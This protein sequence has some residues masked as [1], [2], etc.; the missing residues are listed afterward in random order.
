MLYNVAGY[1]AVHL[2]LDNG[3]AIMIGSDEAQR[4][5]AVI[6]RARQ[7]RRAHASARR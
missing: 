3:K 7:D 6:E 2:E 4:L 5:R 1:D